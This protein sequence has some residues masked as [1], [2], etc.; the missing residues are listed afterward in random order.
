MRKGINF[1]VIIDT[2]FEEMDAIE[3]NGE[4]LIIAKALEKSALT[5]QEIAKNTDLDEPT[6][7][8][9]C[10]DL[11]NENLLLEVDNKFFW[12]PVSEKV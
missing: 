5:S 12:L 9:I 7:I 11:V 8:K 2:R 4:G 6:V 10:N 3:L 1:A